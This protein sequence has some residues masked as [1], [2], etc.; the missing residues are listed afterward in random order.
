MYKLLV[1][2]RA[3]AENL[4]ISVVSGEVSRNDTRSVVG[5]S[6]SDTS[7]GDKLVS[8]RDSILPRELANALN[9]SSCYGRSNLGDYDSL[10]SRY[11]RDRYSVKFIL[12]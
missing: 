1:A 8:Y 4:S 3:I 11:N 7:L 2:S 9:C 12:G 6:S 5:G 10:G